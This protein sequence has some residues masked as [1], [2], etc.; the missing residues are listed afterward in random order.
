VRLEPAPASVTVVKI[1]LSRYN[2]QFRRFASPRLGRTNHAV[3]VRIETGGPLEFLFILRVLPLKET[4][5]FHFPG[6]FSE[7]RVTCIYGLSIYSQYFRHRNF[8]EKIFLTCANL[9]LSPF[10]RFNV[11]VNPWIHPS[12]IREQQTV[13]SRKRP[14]TKPPEARSRN[15]D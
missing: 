1:P 13:R 15:S 10:P 5:E 4:R 2:Q 6:R 3:R 7:G 8:E 9:M 14:L 11:C 12:E